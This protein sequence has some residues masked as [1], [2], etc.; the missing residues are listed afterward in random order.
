MN[1]GKSLFFLNPLFL[2][3]IFSRGYGVI[4]KSIMHDPSLSLE[5]KAIYAYFCSLSGK[6]G[7][8]FP[9]RETILRDLDMNKNTYYKH[10][11]ILLEG[12]YISISRPEDKSAAN[13]YTLCTLE[14]ECRQGY[15]YI[16]RAIMTDPELSVKAKGIYAYFCSYCGMSGQ[17]FPLKKDILFH[18]ALSEP[19]YYKH[20][21]PLKERG[22]LA[23]FQ[24]FENNRF[25]GNTY[26]LFPSLPG[27][28][29]EDFS[30]YIKF[31]DIK[32]ED[33]K[34]EDIYTSNSNTNNNTTII[35]LSSLS[36]TLSLMA[37]RKKDEPVD[38]VIE[39]AW[40]GIGQ[41]ETSVSPKTQEIRAAAWVKKQRDGGGKELESCI[42]HF[43]KHFSV[44]TDRNKIGNFPAYFKKSLL[45]WI[46]EWSLCNAGKGAE[47]QASYSMQEI[48]RL[49][50]E[51]VIL[52]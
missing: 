29:E 45:N 13:I 51:Q 19:T 49:I 5:S 8:T 44:H 40:E 7:Q 34:N 50:R 41:I 30:P 6:D 9:Y 31:W 15:G 3:P 21:Q 17:A 32:N 39:R 48:E 27:S 46:E 37:E 43:A 2:N 12:G 22:L 20:F 47:S 4:P 10:L 52:S 23:A 35:S 25:T 24:G 26:K 42:Q 1:C 16:P 11:H 28:K 33:I 18:L 36:E 38:Q 14:N